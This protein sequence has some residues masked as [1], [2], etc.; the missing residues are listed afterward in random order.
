MPSTAKNF[1][2]KGAS[3]DG[4]DVYKGGTANILPQPNDRKVYTN[5]GSTDLTIA[6]NALTSR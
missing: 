6:G 1:W 5:N 4:A 2:N 3:A